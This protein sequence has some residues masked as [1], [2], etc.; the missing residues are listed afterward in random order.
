MYVFRADLFKVY[1]SLAKRNPVVQFVPPS[2]CKGDA[3]I[4]DTFLMVVEIQNQAN[5]QSARLA[6]DSRPRGRDVTVIY[7]RCRVRDRDRS[8]V[9][10][11]V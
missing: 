2:A 7:V 10:L 9:T 4:L 8:C 5:F 1:K 11:A 6:L 3:D